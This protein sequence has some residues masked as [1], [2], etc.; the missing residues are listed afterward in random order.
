MGNEEEV[1]R[2]L[3]K[4]NLVNVNIEDTAKMSYYEQLKVGA[5]CSHSF[6]GR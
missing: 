4:G 3:A 6:D 2:V 1:K 5:D